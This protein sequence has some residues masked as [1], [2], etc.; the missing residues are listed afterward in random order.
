M[1]Y[2]ISTIS[3]VI[4]IKL[5]LPTGHQ[6]PTHDKKIARI[7]A[8]NGEYPITNQGALDELQHHHNKR[9]KSK[10]KISLYRS[11]NYQSKDIEDIRYGFDQF[12]PVVSHLEFYPQRNPSPPRTLANLLKVL[13]END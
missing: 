2:E 10:V 6:L 9:G 11:N 13:S 5:N 4:D 7:I 1:Y 12:R 3:Y 8:I